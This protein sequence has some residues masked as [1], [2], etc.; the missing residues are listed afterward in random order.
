MA[1]PRGQARGLTW[2]TPDEEQGLITRSQLL[3]RIAGLLGGRVAEEVIFGA[4]EV[5]TGASSDIEKITQ[6]AR[7]MVTRLGMSDLGLVALEEENSNNFLGNDWNRRSE[8]S[9]EIATKIDHEIR[10]IVTACYIKTVLSTRVDNHQQSLISLCIGTRITN[11][12]GRS[13]S[14]YPTRT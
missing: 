8:Y 13:C 12:V 1:H 2:F 9:E 10:D 14:C 4:D 11:M 5:T 6:V 3:A 7:Q